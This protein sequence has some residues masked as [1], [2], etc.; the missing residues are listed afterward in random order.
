[1]NVQGVP[2]SWAILAPRP[3]CPLTKTPP[4]SVRGSGSSQHQPGM[5]YTHIIQNILL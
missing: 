4:T 5:K 2:V 3:P 1:M